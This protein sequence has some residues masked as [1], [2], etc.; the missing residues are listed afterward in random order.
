[1]SAAEPASPDTNL[2]NLILALLTPMFLWSTAGEIRLAHVAAAQTLN[3]YRVANR[4]S[5]FTVAK[6]IAFDIAT[7]SSLSLSMYEDVSMLLALR[8]RGNANSLD[9]SGERNRRLLE[10]QSRTSETEDEVEAAIAEAQRMVNDA[11]ARIQAAEQAQPAAEPAPAVT[12]APAP[13]GAEIRAGGAA[14]ALVSWPDLVRPSTTFGADGTKVVDGQTKSGHDTTG[15][16]AG[17]RL[18]LTRL[19]TSPTGGAIGAGATAAALVSWPDLVRPSTTSG[20]ETDKDVDGRDK[21]DHDTMGRAAGSR[22]T[23]TRL[24]QAPRTVP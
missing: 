16:T 6:I 8:L 15:Q 20:A 21:P 9:R 10:Q 19:G 7:L 22:L 24:G 4:L 14:A 5:L 12:Q 11:K 13:M 18:T 23:L 3:E 2:V 17:S 1:M